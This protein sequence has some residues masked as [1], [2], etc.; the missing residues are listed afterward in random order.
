MS[1]GTNFQIS[2]TNPFAKDFGNPLYPGRPGSSNISNKTPGGFGQPSFGAVTSAATQASA[3]G[4]GSAMVNNR[5]MMGGLGGQQNTPAVSY[6]ATV[7]FAPTPVVAPAMRANLQGIVNRSSFIGVPANVRVE[8]D[9]GTIV[10]R[11]KVADD[12]ERR[13]V[14]S[15]VRL[16]PGV[17]DVRNELKVGP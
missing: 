1:G 5:G 12:D 11:G 10:L 3:T 17:S 9:G 6:A 8:S 15:M 7:S 14:E 13:L 16:E 2:P 4:R